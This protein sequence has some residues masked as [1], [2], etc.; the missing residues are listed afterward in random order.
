MARASSGR[1]YTEYRE[2]L[3][4][5]PPEAA[6]GR[7]HHGGHRSAPRSDEEKPPRRSRSFGQL[8][9][10]FFGLLRGH[11]WAI[12]FAIATLTVST[13]LNLVSPLATKLVIDNVLTDK[14][15]PGWWTNW[16]R[17]PSDRYQVLLLTG[18]FVASVSLVATVVHLMGRWQA[19]KAVNHLQVA[20]RRRV[21]AAAKKYNLDG[22][23]WDID[24]SRFA[25]PGDRPAPALPGNSAQLNLFG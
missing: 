1:R 19:T 22:Y 16:L 5:R 11:E 25:V 12:F 14:P 4:N 6:A 10:E 2:Q 13:L 18:L 21:F 17:L 3:R 9:V 24:S 7:G 8:L 20:I 23:R 15:L